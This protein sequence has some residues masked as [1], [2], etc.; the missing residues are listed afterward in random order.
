MKKILQLVIIVLLLNSCDDGNIAV[1]TINFDDITADSCGEIIYKLKEEES[2]FITIPSSQNAF[3]NDE[4]D[5][6]T[7]TKIQIGGEVSVK[8]R[9][10]DG[11]VSAD[12]IC[13]IAGHITPVA[14]EEWVATSGT[15]EITTTALYANPDATTGQRKIVKYNHYIVFKNIVF[16]K[17]DGTDIKYETFV[18]G[19]Y[20][21][22]A[23]TLSFSFDPKL[24]SSCSGNS[25]IYNA[26]NSG[27]ESLVIENPDADLI[28]NSGTVTRAINSTS[29]KLVYR[30]Y[31]AALPSTLSDYFCGTSTP[32][33][34]TIK[35][36]W[37]AKEGTIEIVNT[38]S[39]G[40][41]HTIRLKMLLSK[42]VIVLF[43]M[44]MIFCMVNSC[45]PTNYLLFCLM[46][47]SVAP[48]PYFW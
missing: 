17:P 39:G 20:L 9:F 45:C 34:P 13:I 1:E 15:I 41:L 25:K 47:T 19:D 23:N 18:F 27:F 35:E 21:T 29:N 30:L 10:Y 5:S 48:K 36:E 14:I 3:T 38:T 31:N 8:Y 46:Y 26:R 2:L 43:I 24:L 22:N 32:L 12:N 33:T 7:P 28:Q 16:A 42:E 40:F 44:A 6:G 4:T 37:I 11:K